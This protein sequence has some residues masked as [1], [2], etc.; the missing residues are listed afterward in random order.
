M[1]RKLQIKRQSYGRLL[2]YTKKYKYKLIAG[3]LAGFLTGGFFG[4]SFFWLQGFVQPYEKASGPSIVSHVNV[5]ESKRSADSQE[6]SHSVVQK[7]MGKNSAQILEIIKMAKFFGIKTEDKEG[8]M[9]FV[10]LL[11]FAISFV[12]VWF[13][14]NFFLYINRYYMRWVGSRVVADMREDIFNA[15][16][17][18]S[19]SFYG[20]AD[21]GQLISRCIEDTNQIQSAV[22]NSLEDLTSCPFQILGCLGFIVYVSINNQNIVLP[23]TI[24]LGVILVVGP[25][26]LIGRK[27]RNIYRHSYQKIAEVVSRMHE[28][29]TG[30]ILVKAYHTELAESEHFR[31]VNKRF[32]KTLLKALK[33]EL[34]M[35]PL[36]EFCGITAI[37]AFFIYSYIAHVTLSEI[38]M[39]IVPAMLA[40][41]PIKDLVKV[42]TSIQKSMAAADRYFDIIDTDTSIKEVHH[43]K[44]IKEFKDKILFNNVSF[45][46]GESRPILDN[47]NFTLERGKMVAVVGETGSGKTTI[48]NLIARFYDV[49]SGNITID[50]TDVRESRI[51][52]L[53][54]LIGIVTQSTILFN[55]TIANN[56]AYGCNNVSREQIVE[57]A[58]Q[59]NAHQFI[60]GGNHPNG[61]DT[62][63]GDKGFILSGGEKQRIAIARA[64]LKNPPILI[65]D[66]A[67]SAL[68]TVTERLVQDALNNLMENR[69]V[70]AIAH[71]LSTIKHADIIIVL[72]KGEIIESGNH[73]ELMAKVDGR[74]RK[75]HEIQFRH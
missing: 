55:D 12:L 57:A 9:T 19:L 6:A 38:V 73:E 27:V 23:F 25:L 69:T 71:R 14:K 31:I 42:N 24:L 3:I 50:G 49:S 54:D 53:R 40:Y 21:V 44:D 16:L 4:A 61:Y 7:K 51:K 46:Y 45:T 41:Q 68:D 39:L 36:T 30:I 5:I 74:Y 64:I 28:V 70:F 48:A 37:V 35:Q 52:S 47:I 22:S 29:F 62:V 60:I 8:R 26:V 75:L 33:V 1:N 15:L 67:T 43:P 66:E 72:D 34:I 63:V 20:K 2:S 59:A 17:K 10:A 56:I 13:C 58:K 32:F 18:Q 65:L 11:I